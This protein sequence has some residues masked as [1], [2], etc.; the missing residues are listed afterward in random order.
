[1]HIMVVKVRDV[2]LNRRAT[3]RSYDGCLVPAE[4]SADFCHHVV[5]AHE[6]LVF[7]D[8][9]HVVGVHEIVFV[10]ASEWRF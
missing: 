1:M 4:A 8:V 9:A 10:R 5:V 7:V 2:I 3:R 6:E